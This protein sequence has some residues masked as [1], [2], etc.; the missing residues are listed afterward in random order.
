MNY[1]SPTDAAD[2]YASWMK[3]LHWVNETH[4]VVPPFPLPSGRQ[5]IATEVAMVVRNALW[6]NPM[7]LDDFV[8]HN[9]AKLSPAALAEVALWRHR[10]SGKFTLLQHRA[11]G[12][13]FLGPDGSEGGFEVVGISHPIADTLD[14]VPVFVLATLL[15]FRDR[16]VY[17]TFISSYPV[18]FGAGARR[19]MVEAYK[20][21]KAS[22]LILSQLPVPGASP[23]PKKRASKRAGAKVLPLEPKGSPLEDPAVLAFEAARIDPAHFGHREHLY[24]AW[25]YLRMLPV[26]DALAR[27]MKGL[28]EVVRVLGVPEK[29]HVTMTW[30]Y[31]VLLAEA[32]HSMPG[33]P[34][35]ALMEANPRLLT[36][37]KALL[38]EHW[39]AEELA[40]PAARARFVLPRRRRK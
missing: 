32:M 22:G 24:V 29:L 5:P 37:G 40:S 31:L 27:Y 12:S 19:M 2:F 25:C 14:D 9:P 38:E 17:D 20:K 30:G 33:A 8:K 1:L 3:L 4:R 11:S 39:S 21:A 36:G 10:V 15:P 6:A 18:R 13:V 34:F 7:V 26:E 28:R 35:D 23:S 16:I